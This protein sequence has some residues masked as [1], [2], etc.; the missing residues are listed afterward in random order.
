MKADSALGSTWEEVRQEIFTPAEIAASDARVKLMIELRRLRKSRGLTQKQL[1]ELT[2][3]S[4]PLISKIESGDTSPQV[5]TLIKI[6][7]AM[8]MKIEVV[9]RSA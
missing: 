8:E 2:G 3:I 6:L 9:P 5:D 7:S 1:S 4:Q